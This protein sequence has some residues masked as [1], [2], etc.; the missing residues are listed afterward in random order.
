MSLLILP[1]NSDNT[2]LREA[3]KSICEDEGFKIS[4]VPA[5]TALTTAKKLYEWMIYEGNKQPVDIFSKLLV[6]RLKGCIEQ[7]TGS[8]KAHRDKMWRNFHAVRVSTSFKMC[9]KNFLT[10]A[11]SP[12]LYQRLSDLIMEFQCSDSTEP[13]ITPLTYED[14]NALRYVAGY[15]CDKLR[16]KISASKLPSKESL[17]LCLSELCDEDEVVSSS[18]D[19]MHAIDRGGLCH[20]NENT[21]SLFAQIEIVVRSV[22]RVKSA[23]EVT[24]G[25]RDRV[26]QIA[27]RF[28]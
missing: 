21:F 27:F 2:L 28:C 10:L 13:N 14:K 25:L 20:V 3:T 12:L 16:I 7:I 24:S 15:V 5:S 18:A 26:K 9:W 11:N 19:W 1:E 17:L 4:A 22:F 6:D 23:Q 8:H